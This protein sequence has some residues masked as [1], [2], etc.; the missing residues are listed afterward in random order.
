MSLQIVKESRNELLGRKEVDC[1]FNSMAGS[2]K[3][4][5]AVNMVAKSLKVDAIKVHLICLM[6]NT[7]TRNV[8]GLFYVYDRPEDA[9]KQLPE[10]LS[11]RM[12]PKA[13]REKLTKEAKKREPVKE[14]KAKRG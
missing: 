7:G 10:Y 3:R 12:L 5:D 9:R 2:L 11:L 1:I 14:K 8:S 13:E 6:T 4:Q